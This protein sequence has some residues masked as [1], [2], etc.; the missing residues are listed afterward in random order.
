MYGV[1]SQG[2]KRKT[3]EEILSDMESRARNLFGDDIDLSE[4]SPIGIILRIIAYEKSLEWQEAENTYYSGYKDTA[5]GIN[6]DYVAKY[7]GIRRKQAEK[8][9]VDLQFTG[10]PGTVIPKGFK[11]ETGGDNS[12]AFLTDIEVTID[13]TGNATVK[14]TAEEAGSSYNVQANTITVITNPTPGVDSVNNLNAATGGQDQESDA[15]F[16]KRY[17]DSIEK[18]GT[19][20]VNAILAAVREVATD[21]QVFKNNSNTTDADG[22]PPKSVEVVVLGGTDEDIAYAI[23]NSIAAGIEP[24]GTT[25]Y[26]VTDDAGNQHAVKF[27]RA[28]TK[29]IYVTLDIIKNANYV[30]DD[31][32]KDAVIS[33]IGGTKTDSSQVLG[34][35]FGQDV[36]YSKVVAAVAS[37]EGIDDVTVKIGTTS[38]PTATSNITVESTEVAQ[39]DST[40]VVINY[41]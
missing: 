18:G 26:T 31:A 21:V 37:L 19:A 4:T 27:S 35:S 41:V 34:L 14:A 33:Y 36:I 17:D 23:F 5:E 28:T 29:D 3:Y 10:T 15:E 6:L 9:I 1:T 40:K 32:V 8:A 25:S 2:F 24:Y 11:V 12:K 22:R 39:T 16:R 38:N 20:T 7:I 30:G 13:A